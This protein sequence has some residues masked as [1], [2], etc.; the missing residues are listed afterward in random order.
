MSCT[1]RFLALFLRSFLHFVNFHENRIKIKFCLFNSLWHRDYFF[2]LLLIFF[3]RLSVLIALRHFEIYKTFLKRLILHF[4]PF[5]TISRQGL[6][7]T[8]GIYEG[9]T[10]DILYVDAWP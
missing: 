10:V 6:T 8:S 7:Y 9:S 4:K 2:R 5:L 1:V 3:S